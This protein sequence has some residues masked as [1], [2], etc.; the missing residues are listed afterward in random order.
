LLRTTIALIAVAVSAAPT[1]NQR[2]STPSADSSPLPPTHRSLKTLP[3]PFPE[4]AEAGRRGDFATARRLL[5]ELESSD[6]EL[7]SLALLL[8]GFYAHANEDHELAVSLLAGGTQLPGG[9]DDWRLFIR[10]E[11]ARAAGDLPTAD[12][13]LQELLGNHTGTPLHAQSL[14]AL[15]ELA[16]QQEDWESALARIASARGADLPLAA[17]RRL[18]LSGWEIAQQ[19][20]RQDLLAATARRLLVAYPLD[21]AELGVLQALPELKDEADLGRLLSSPELESRARNLLAG[22]R[23]RA[24]LETLEQVSEEARNRDWHLLWA[25]A[26]TEDHQGSEALAALQ[27]LDSEAAPDGAELDWYRARAALDA[28]SVRRGRRNLP[29]DERQILRTEALQL[30]QRIADTGADR[31]RAL[32]ALRL[33]FSELSDDEEFFEGNLAILRRLQQLNAED[34]TGTRYLWYLGWQAYSN[35]NYTAAIGYW[36]ELDSLYPG[37]RHG[38]SGR[39]WTARAHERL[40][41]DDRAQDIYREIAA[42][43]TTDFYRRH[44]LARLRPD[45]R[46][47]HTAPVTPVEPWPWDAVLRRARWLHEAGLAQQVMIELEALEALADRRAFCALRAT[48]LAQLG[49]RRESIQA[50]ACAFPTLG[51]VRQSVVPEQALRLYYP[52]D[53]REL[54]NDHA[55]GKNL[56]PYLVF[57]MVRQE[58]AFDAEARSRAGARGLMQMMPSTGR[59]LARRLGL[60]YSTSRLNDPDFSIRLGTQYFR[61]VLDMFGGNQ[62]LALAGYNGGPYRIKR[63]WGQAGS[64]PELDQFLE[65]LWLEETKTYVKRILLFEDS[66]RRLYGEAG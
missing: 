38:R 25:E 9:L 20:D 40:G 30:L 45:N 17:A 52:V 8:S 5:S 33:R 16:R 34:K 23:A 28:A 50:L 1:H 11:A 63:L 21:A 37:T 48:A 24:A 54:I 65:G 47:P 14:Q 15:V 2:P 56:S 44:A 26:L 61:Q 41:H 42:A 57:A 58:S 10:A 12:E 60:R 46:L 4:S 62:E 3:S 66:Y 43:E 36:S 53:Y 6:G 13:A 59:E 22:G 18:E 19:L 39:Y 32:A 64:R 49:R 29:R 31:A 35:R 27:T 55:R 51:H 7:E